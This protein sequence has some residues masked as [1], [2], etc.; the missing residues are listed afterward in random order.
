[1]PHARRTAPRA[2][3]RGLCALALSGAASASHAASG[4]VVSARAAR[5]ATQPP[6]LPLEPP[7]SYADAHAFS[8]ARV[9]AAWANATQLRCAS[10]RILR[11]ASESDLGA[12]AR[13][14][15]FMRLRAD[16]TDAATAINGVRHAGQRARAGAAGAAE[17]GSVGA[18][19]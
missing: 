18:R 16:A 13:G 10:A 5:S 9:A 14:D 17:R 2:L 3:L 19:V 12:E 7:I 11:G 6:A 4:R 8:V 15:G 1:M